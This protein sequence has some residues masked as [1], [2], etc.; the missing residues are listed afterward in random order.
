METKDHI[1]IILKRTFDV[2]GDTYKSQRED[3]C[4]APAGKSR[5][6]F[7][8]KSDGKIRVSEQE[9]RFI[10]VEQLI[11]Y[12]RENWDVYYSIE[13]PTEYNYRFPADGV[14]ECHVTEPDGRSANIDLSIHNTNGQRIA[15]IEFKHGH[16]FDAMNKDFLKLAMEPGDSERFFVGLLTSSAGQTVESISQKISNEKSALNKNT[17]FIYYSLEHVNKEPDVLFGK[18]F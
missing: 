10:F 9:M 7:P 1:G 18:E 14:P 2:I 11:E 17:H 6:I 12:A 3:S 13:T 5:L 4:F 15:L 8:K 16:D